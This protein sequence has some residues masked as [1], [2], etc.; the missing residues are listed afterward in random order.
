[1]SNIN[2]NIV[3]Y[4][5][6]IEEL[7]NTNLSILKTINESFTTTKKN[8]SVTIGDTTYTIPSCLSIENKVNSLQDTIEGVLNIPHTGEACYN[9]DGNTRT[10]ELR[11][12]SYTPN[13]ININNNVST[14]EESKNNLFRELLTPTP[15]VKFDVNL[16]ND[17]FE[18]KVRKI[19]SKSSSCDDKFNSLLAQ[20]NES[21]SCLVD[22]SNINS[23]VSSLNANDYEVYDKIYKLDAR[24]SNVGEGKYEI[25][26]ILN[27]YIDEDGYEVY[28]L[29]VSSNSKLTYKKFDGTIEKPLLAGDFLRNSDGTAKVLVTLVDSLNSVI[30]IKLITGDALNLIPSNKANNNHNEYSYLY[31]FNGDSIYSKSGTYNTDLKVSL[32]EDKYVFIC[33]SLINSRLNVQ[34]E[35]GNGIL[36]NTSNLALSDGTNFIDYYNERVKN[37]GDALLEMSSSLTSPISSIN[38]DVYN[39]LVNAKPIISDELLKVVEINKHLKGDN[40]DYLVSSLNSLNIRYESAMQT[41][42]SL[43][44]KTL[45]ITDPEYTTLQNAYDTRDACQ[46]EYNTYFESTDV[47]TVLSY[48]PKYRI[49][50]FI[51]PNL[52]TSIG[53]LLFDN[54]NFTITSNNVEINII[55]M[56]IQYAYNNYNSSVTN[57]VMVFTD[58]SN[59]DKQFVYPIW[60]DVPVQYRNK[61]LSFENNSISYNYDNITTDNSIKFN[62][63][64][65]P[66]SENET[67]KIRVKFIY[68]LGQP[69]NVISTQWSDSIDIK[70]D[71]SILTQTNVSNIVDLA[72]D[73]MINI[74][75]DNIITT[76]GIK[77]HIKYSQTQTG[78]VHHSNTI[79]SGFR[80]SEQNIISL[81]QKLRELTDAIT[82]IRSDMSDDLNNIEVSVS[83]GSD[84]TILSHSTDNFINLESYNSIYT[85][86]LTSLSATEAASVSKSS[87]SNLANN[88]FTTIK[89]NVN[90]NNNDY[91][92]DSSDIVSTMLNINIRNKGNNNIKLYS[93]F[94]GK[95][96]IKLNESTARFVDVN[97]YCYTENNTYYGV[98]YKYTKNE[99]AE[100]NNV[101]NIKLQTQN[102]F[103]TFRINDPW[104]GTKYYTTDAAVD[105]DNVQNFEIKNISITDNKGLVVYPYLNNEHGLCL[106]TDDLKTFITIKPGDEI[107]IPMYCSY[108]ISASDPNTSASIKKTISFDLRTSL[109]TDPINYTFTVVASNNNTIQSKLAAVNRTRYWNKLMNKFGVNTDKTV[110]VIK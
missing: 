68:D 50:G 70:F 16:P 90:V 69:F 14:F 77:D 36:I 57:N 1:M 33:V 38:T 41:I 92:I 102:Q 47:N 17:I 97:N 24:T 76:S 66:I 12:Y 91:I 15:V 104:D 22:Y 29:K 54:D 42:K 39:V 19:I 13:T 44:G 103:I 25:E 86:P 21:T 109:Y 53:N 23:I 37:I 2:T 95:R 63:V 9:V 101:D 20:S 28:E 62:Q 51:T 4:F 61:K 65:I 89:N 73:N 7:T 105:S 8:V 78:F 49:R 11:Q 108:K 30:K 46:N 34:S 10:I 27:T 40:F 84:D 98:K 48:T 56:Q 79:D 26:D 99:D 71:N 67:I 35:W 110:S 43:E 87:V 3:D 64:D 96:D 55:G 18:V 80:T 83:L 75:A 45:T 107:N 59:N 52:G 93:L 88:N 74:K 72:N 31:Y 5:N 60:N 81:E 82:D 106:P 6:K 100:S 94:P 85:A 58:G 32:E